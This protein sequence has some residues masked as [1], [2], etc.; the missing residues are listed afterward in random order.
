M[1]LSLY[2]AVVVERLLCLVQ[3]NAFR[4]RKA[5]LERVELGWVGYSVFLFKSKKQA[6]VDK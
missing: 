2:T 1:A 3:V 5:G 4:I 6:W